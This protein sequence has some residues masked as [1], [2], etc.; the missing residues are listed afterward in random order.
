MENLEEE[1]TVGGEHD[2]GCAA[3]EFD[4]TGIARKFLEEKERDRNAANG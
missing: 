1:T 3:I 2:D 4:V